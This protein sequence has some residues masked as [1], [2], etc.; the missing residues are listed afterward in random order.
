MVVDERQVNLDCNV[1]TYAVSPI[2]LPNSTTLGREPGGILCA[3]KAERHCA[4]SH[5]AVPLLWPSSS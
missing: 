5:R 2:P 4:P 3:K 1:R